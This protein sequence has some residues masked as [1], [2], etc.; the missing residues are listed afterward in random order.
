MFMAIGCPGG[1]FHRSC[2][3]EAPPV[4]GTFPASGLYCSPAMS[5]PALPPPFPFR[6]HP[7]QIA[8]LALGLLG[9][10]LAAGV[11]LML[12]S[13]GRQLAM[14][15]VVLH[16][17]PLAL[18]AEITDN[19]GCAPL[20]QT[21]WVRHAAP[22]PKYFSVWVYQLRPQARGTQLIDRHVL[23][24]RLSAGGSWLF[25]GEEACWPLC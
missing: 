10:L 25:P 14:R 4:I 3:W 18:S 15:T 7:H 2:K 24:L 6:F 23:A 12:L 1:L 13:W 17:G 8:G 16:V 21:C 20:S 19:P 9:L 22:R 11:C 5:T